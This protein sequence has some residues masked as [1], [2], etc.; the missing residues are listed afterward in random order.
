MHT[1]TLQ[2]SFKSLGI[3]DLVLTPGA[4]FRYLS[5]LSMHASERLTLLF[6]N[7]SGEK[8]ALLPELE[9]ESARSADLLH[10]ETYRDEEGPLRALRNLTQKMGF[11]SETVLGYEAQTI[12][13]FEYQALTGASEVTFRAADDALTAIR[14]IKRDDELAKIRRAAQIVD[15]ALERSLPL[16]K[17]GMT[18]LDVAAELEYQM[19]KLGSEGTPFATIA[20]AGPRGALPHGGPTLSEIKRG[21]L[22]V[23][24]YGAKIDGYA[25][26]TTRTVSFGVPSEEA[27]SIYEVVKM[28][29]AAAVN[30][31]KPGAVAQDVDRAARKVIQKAGLGAY[32]THRTGHGLGL[33]VHEYPSMMEGNEL[34][35]APGMVFT[36]EPGVYLP[37][38]F[39]IRIEDDVCVTEAGVEVLTQF[40]RELHVID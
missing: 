32:F 2:N 23:L 35:L 8:S 27:L 21:D 22:V 7:K 1:H 39:G 38:K 25:A 14:L 26:D 19:R 3:T 20:C 12:R 4:S 24:D 15:G 34:I 9:A 16:F 29:Q 11:T 13:M 40:T 10:I 28:A 36:V 33:D 6:V 30:A 17:V 18:E 31:V 37:N 5:G